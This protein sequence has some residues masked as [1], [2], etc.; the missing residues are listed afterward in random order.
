VGNRF[1]ADSD[2]IIRIIHLERPHA[3]RGSFAVNSRYVLRQR[4][5]DCLA[6]DPGPFF[7][8][9]RSKDLEEESFL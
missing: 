2:E 9:P 8:T 6:G 5:V 1:R 4:P 7:P 3:R